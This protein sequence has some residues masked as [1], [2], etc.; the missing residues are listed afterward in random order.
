MLTAKAPK[1]AL[2]KYVW[3][4]GLLK[5]I[6]TTA[7]VLFLLAVASTGGGRGGRTTGQPRCLQMSQRVHTSHPISKQRAKHR[8]PQRGLGFLSQGSLSENGQL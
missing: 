3:S 2:S 8:V 1:A 5:V 4:Q 7:L 6:D